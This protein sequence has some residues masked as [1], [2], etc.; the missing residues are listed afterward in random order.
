[1]RT[2][3]ADGNRIRPIEKAITNV[4]VGLRDLRVIYIPDFCV[5]VRGG[6]CWGETYIYLKDNNYTK[7]TK[8]RY[9]EKIRKF[10]NEHNEVECE[11]PNSTATSYFYVCWVDDLEEYRYKYF[12]L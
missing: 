5:K 7:E 11:W 12:K 9:E 1:M 3:L 2:S 8:I 10:L 6:A 4:L